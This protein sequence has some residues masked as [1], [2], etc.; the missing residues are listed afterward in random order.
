MRKRIKDL[1]AKEFEAWVENTPIGRN[2]ERM[3]EEAVAG[4]EPIDVYNGAKLILHVFEQEID[5][6]E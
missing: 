2:Y 4:D 1:T 5:I 6:D 3:L